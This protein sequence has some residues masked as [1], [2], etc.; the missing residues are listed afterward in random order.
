VDA[1]TCRLVGHDADA[2]DA[3]VEHQ[4]GDDVSGFMLGR[5]STLTQGPWALPVEGP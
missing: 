4:S 2:S 5:P 3:N 1:P